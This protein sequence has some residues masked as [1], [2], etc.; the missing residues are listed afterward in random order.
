MPY[1]VTANVPVLLIPARVA[2]RVTF[3]VALTFM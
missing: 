3:T 2:V 1:G